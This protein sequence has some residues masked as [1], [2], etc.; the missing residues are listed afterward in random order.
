MRKVDRTFWK[1]RRVLITGHSG[2]KG[3]WLCALLQLLEADIRGIAL[4]TAPLLPAARQRVLDVRDQAALLKEF[5][6]FRPEVIFHLAA[7]SNIQQAIQEP[8]LCYE[9][10]VTGTANVLEAAK[11]TESVRA[12]VVVTSDKCYRVK[13]LGRGFQEADELGGED[14]YSASKAACELVVH[15]FRSTYCPGGQHSGRPLA[16]ATARC[17]NLIAGGDETGSRL[18]PGLAGSLQAGGRL[19]L[20]HPSAV[21]PWLYVL[22]ALHGYLLLAES[23]YADGASMAGAWNF[24]PPTTEIKTVGE[25]ADAFCK[26]WGEGAA[27]TADAEVKDV[28]TAFLHLDAQ[29]SKMQLG[30]QGVYGFEQMVESTVAYYKMQAGGE[31]RADIIARQASAYIRDLE[32][33]HIEGGANRTRLMHD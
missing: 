7:I 10:N 18:V 1:N 17:C 15:A 21:R 4:D 32:K 6:E 23:L 29:K 24:A 20:R 25:L 5:A 33:Q 19:H 8:A 16:V 30:W 3:A 27:Y 13:P 14:P 9:T 22:D 11:Q 31:R 2:Y 12:V 26:H 28:E